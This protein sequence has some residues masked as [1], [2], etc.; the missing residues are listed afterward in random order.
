MAGQ[1]PSL[2]P[3]A[4]ALLHI[5][6]LLAILVLWGSALILWPV[7]APLNVWG[8]LSFPANAVPTNLAFVP[9]LPV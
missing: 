7:R 4:V 8:I 3:Y 1:L 2:S 5:V 9:A 6:I